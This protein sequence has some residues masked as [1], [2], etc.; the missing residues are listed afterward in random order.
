[1]KR[2]KEDINIEIAENG[3][4][5]GNNQ[6]VNK[7][8]EI[9]DFEVCNKAYIKDK[10]IQ[11]LLKNKFNFI[12]VNLKDLLL[13]H[14]LFKSVKKTDITDT[15][16][17]TDTQFTIEKAEDNTVRLY[18]EEMLTDHEVT[19]AL[20]ADKKFACNKVTH[21]VFA[22]SCNTSFEKVLLNFDLLQTIAR[23]AAIY[24]IKNNTEEK[25]KLGMSKNLITI[26][27]KDFLIITTVRSIK[28]I[29]KDFCN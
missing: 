9:E 27:F 6:I 13:A 19:S 10:Q 28:K 29:K 4:Q 21:E 15:D 1:M 11:S 2:I 17:D 5:S 7:F 24:K 25:I 14:N 23:I 3:D 20:H 12:S 22:D 8:S 16:R 26:N 18:M